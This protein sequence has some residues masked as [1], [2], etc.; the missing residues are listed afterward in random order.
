MVLSINNTCVL[1]CPIVLFA[2]TIGELSFV[3]CLLLCVPPVFPSLVYIF[4]GLIYSFIG[5][6]GVVNWISRIV[7]L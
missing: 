7:G 2:D 4:I 6:V 3:F 1:R 5:A